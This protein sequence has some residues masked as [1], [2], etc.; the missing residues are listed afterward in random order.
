MM[1]LNLS[2]NLDSSVLKK[3]TLDQDALYDLLI[4]GSGPAGLNAAL[5]GARKG[6]KLGIL[7]L[8]KG[9][10]VLDTSSV[11]NFIGVEDIS[12]EALAESFAA[13]VKKLE[14]PIYDE[15]EVVDYFI[16]NNLH[17]VVLSSGETYKSKTM[18]LAT[19]S[20]PRRLDVPGEKEYAGKG[21]AYCAICD[22]PLFKDRDVFVAGGGNSAV[23]A[24][25]DLAKLAR[26]V[27]LVHRSL[28]R[29]DQ[30]LIDQIN[31]DPKITVHLKT[32][33]TEIVGDKAM[34]GIRVEDTD[35][36][37]QRVLS[38]DGIFIEIG[39]LPN[40]GPFKKHVA[41]NAQ[42]EILTSPLKET[43]V[44]G[45]FAAGDVTGFPYKQIVIAASDGAVAALAANDYI[46][47]QG[48]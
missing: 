25:L 19:G 23:E 6:L 43:N 4:V 35:T 12:G 15:S 33:I 1:T 3:T 36:G 26:S 34:N 39:Y 32:K 28:L 5:Y 18:I 20:K 31:A 14:V 41:V 22:G 8:K 7:G 46:Q 11:D 27:T 37:E 40:T 2:F 48:L 29:A 44:P 47:K 38:G 21:V 9:G 13:H 16:D 45:L 42:G 17:H 30:I 24:A 10:Q